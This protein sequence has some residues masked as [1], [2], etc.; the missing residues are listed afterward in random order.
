MVINVPFGYVDHSDKLHDIICTYQKHSL[1]DM[2]A[3]YY[4]V[5]TT[6]SMNGTN[7]HVSAWKWINSYRT[8]IWEK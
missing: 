2:Q 5:D 6:D 3:H 1:I 8:E 4:K 7:F